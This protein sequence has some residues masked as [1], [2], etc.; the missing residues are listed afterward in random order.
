MDR[1]NMTYTVNLKLENDK[2]KTEIKKLRDTLEEIILVREE[3]MWDKTKID[4]MAYLA[5]QALKDG[6]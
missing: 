4:R 3:E 2:L 5:K 1:F 6:E